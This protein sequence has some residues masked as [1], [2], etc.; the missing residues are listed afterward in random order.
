MPRKDRAPKKRV[1][2]GIYQLGPGLFELAV[3]AGKD[4]ATGRYRQVFRRHRGT[5]RGK[6]REV[7]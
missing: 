3:S 4:P 2:R 1:D 7:V 5:L 6:R